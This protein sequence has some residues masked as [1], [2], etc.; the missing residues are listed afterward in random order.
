[1]IDKRNNKSFEEKILTSLRNGKV[2]YVSSIE[3]V[4]AIRELC[5]EKEYVVAIKDSGMYKLKMRRR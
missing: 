1:M 3:R 2:E 4:R 5:N